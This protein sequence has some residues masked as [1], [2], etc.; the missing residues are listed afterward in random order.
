MSDG[1]TNAHEFD[2][3]ISPRWEQLDVV[4][5]GQLQGVLRHRKELLTSRCHGTAGGVGEPITVVRVDQR[6]NLELTGQRRNT[7]NVV[8]VS[9][10]EQDGGRRQAVL[11]DDLVHA[12]DRLL[13][14][15]DDHARLART[16]RHDVTVRG[17][18][19]SRE[20][21]DK[22]GSSWARCAA[23]RWVRVF[24]EVPSDVPPAGAPTSKH[25]LASWRPMSSPLH[26]DAEHRMSTHRHRLS[27]RT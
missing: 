24:W 10:R 8:H 11:G 19:S 13:A 27:G 26:S 3:G 15:I 4:W 20:A 7:P 22:Q 21:G 6:W 16:R 18:R 2:L 12:V 5:F 17:P 25:S 14:G 1:K 9:V 23:S